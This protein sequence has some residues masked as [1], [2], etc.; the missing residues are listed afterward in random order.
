[1]RPASR[2][3]ILCVRVQQQER[4]NG[5]RAVCLRSPL[6]QSARRTKEANERCKLQQL[7]THSSIGHCASPPRLFQSNK[8]STSRAQLILSATEIRISER[9]ELELD[10]K[11]PLCCIRKKRLTNLR[12]TRRLVQVHNNHNAHNKV[13]ANQQSSPL[14]LHFHHQPS[15]QS[16]YQL[17]QHCSLASNI[18]LVHKRTITHIKTQ[19]S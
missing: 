2:C 12:P 18:I 17:N 7:H 9:S 13:H 10:L 19:A 1:M 3:K 6:A 8:F 5:C 14:L 15:N 11:A 4:A 16:H